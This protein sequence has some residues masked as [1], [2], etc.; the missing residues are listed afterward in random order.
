M[1]DQLR[2]E[3][4]ARMEEEQNLRRDS[5]NS[6]DDIQ[7]IMHMLEVDTQNSMWL[8]EMIEQHGWPTRSLVGEEAAQAAFLIVQHSPAL[9]F[10]KKCLQLL[11][12]A[13]QEN[14]ADPISLA[15]LTDRIRISEG[16]PQRYGT[17]GQTSPDGSITPFPIEDEEQ[18]DERRK[19][20]GLEP[21]VE[22]F[23][24]MN[25]RYKTQTK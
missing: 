21:V 11:E 10:Q 20:I 5:I 2:N 6:P 15:Y 14:E 13:V 24:S 17:Q 16:K 3:L 12:Q 23:K 19:A 22:Y 7:L 1:N 8:D 18:V 4:L 9:E 25:Q